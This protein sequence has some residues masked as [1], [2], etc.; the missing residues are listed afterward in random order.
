MEREEVDLVNE[1][2]FI[3]YIRKNVALKVGQFGYKQEMITQKKFHRFSNCR[4]NIN[5]LWKTA[6]EDGSWAMNFLEISFEGITYFQ[7][8]FKDDSQAT[9]AVII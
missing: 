8:L 6:K 4:K 1:S 3:G 9:I 5:S 7:S 2:N